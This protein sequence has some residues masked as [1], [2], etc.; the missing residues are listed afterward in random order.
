MR[1][2]TKRALGRGAALNGNG[3]GNGRAVLPPTAGVVI[4]RYRQP[5]PARRGPVAIVGRI[6]LWLL[7]VLMVVGAGLAGGAYLYYHETLSDIT[8]S[9]PEIRD[10]A[11]VLDVPIPGAP[12]IALAIGYDKRVGPEAELTGR[13]DTVMLIRAD[14]RAKAVSTLAFPRDLLVEVRCPG[15]APRLGPINSAYT[16][17]QARGV[18]E[19]VKGR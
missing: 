15:Q 16:S 9:T 18:L 7:A 1:T 6:V 4:T 13:S 5:Q 8:A 17:C 12:A 19:T 11:R 10:A 2:T 14:P 3:T